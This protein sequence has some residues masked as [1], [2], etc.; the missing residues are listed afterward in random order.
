MRVMVVARAFAGL[1][2]SLAT[3]T[4]QPRGVPAIYKLLEALADD[5]GIEL[6]PVFAVKDAGA[7]RRLGGRRLTVPRLGGETH[8]LAW[9]P[10]PW[11]AR[12]G[13]DGTLRELDHAWRC[14]ALY[15]RYRPR[16]SYFTN[17]NFVSAGLVARLGLGRVV[18]RLLG[19]HPEQWRLARGGS[20]PQ[21]WFYRAPFAHVVCTLDG[22][23]TDYYLPRLLRPGQACSVL[24]NGVDRA[25]PEPALVAAFK[26]GLGLG[27]RPVVLF[28]GRLEWNKGCSEF[29]EAMIA[30]VGRRPEAAD[31]LVVGAGSLGPTLEAAVAAAGLGARI[32]FTGALAHEDVACAFAAAAV[33]VSLNR[34]GSLSNANLEALAAGR[35]TVVLEPDPVAH[36]DEETEAMLPRDAVLRVPRRDT[37]A[38][39][40]RLLDRLLADP[41]RIAAHEAA[42]RRLADRLLESWA[43]RI[44]RE[45][46]IIRMAADAVTED[47]D[48]RCR[49]VPG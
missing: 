14:L 40:A 18:L 45:V 5:P 23:G 39:L 19:L 29:V 22:S 36:V 20:P 10:R 44:A 17:A 1:V 49:V 41:A 16:V 32:R 9:R 28:V 6:I 3:G 4:W 37:A 31:A 48:V 26:A 25:A 8:L 7:A 43:V 2:D 15:R 21:R 35:C 34:L 38:A 24:P 30:L 11:L 47:P 42:T 13:L 27:A 12:L 46:G 33:Y